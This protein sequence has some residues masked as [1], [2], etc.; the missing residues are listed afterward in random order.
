M[1]QP[2]ALT[3]LD[4]RDAPES[5]LV[6]RAR[7]RDESAVR[8]LTRR[9]NRRLFRIARGILRDETDAEDAVQEA[10]VSAFTRLARFRGE[11]SF[12]TW[13]TRIVLNEALG[14]RRRR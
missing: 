10:Y 3:S 14:R 11:S 1:P 7:Q 9:Y 13:L 2:A 8:E 4:I 12:G 5:S 6:A